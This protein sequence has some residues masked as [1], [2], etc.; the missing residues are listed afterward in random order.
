MEK[1]MKWMRFFFLQ[2]QQKSTF[3]TRFLKLKKGWFTRIQLDWES[4]TLH[5][6]NLGFRTTLADTVLIFWIEWMEQCFLREKF[7][8]CGRIVSVCLRSSC[9]VWSIARRRR[10]V[11]YFCSASVVCTVYA[12]STVDKFVFSPPPRSFT[13]PVRS[14]SSNRRRRFRLFLDSSLVSHSLAASR[15]K[16]QKER[17]RRTPCACR[18]HSLSVISVGNNIY[19]ENILFSYFE[20]KFNNKNI[21]NPFTFDDLIKIYRHFSFQAGR[22]L[23]KTL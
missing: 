5:E 16:K 22:F 8:R 6:G 3:S 18:S 10:S 17:R 13:F 19:Q 11:L 1:G 12:A 20:W 23:K 14:A 7:A 21:W 15:K 2:L 4:Q 9:G